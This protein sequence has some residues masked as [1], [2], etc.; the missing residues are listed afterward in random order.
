MTKLDNFQALS[1]I[2]SVMKDG[3]AIKTRVDAEE[4]IAVITGKSDELQ[5]KYFQLLANLGSSYEDNKDIHSALLYYK[6]IYNF[7]LETE[8]KMRSELGLIMSANVYLEIDDYDNLDRVCKLNDSLASN[9]GIELWNIWKT[10]VS[11]NRIISKKKKS[12]WVDFLDIATT[13][14]CPTCGDR[15]EGGTGGD[16]RYLCPSCG[17]LF[18]P[19]GNAVN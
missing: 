9:S 3:V 11:S 12:G 4:K 8:D 15:M 2:E 17:Q 10:L 19:K 14:W 13:F 7:G 16:R 18:D 5:Q 1:L 6:K